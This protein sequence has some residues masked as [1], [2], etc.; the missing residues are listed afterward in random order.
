[1]QRFERICIFI[2]NYPRFIER[3]LNPTKPLQKT[4][5]EFMCTMLDKCAQ[6]NIYWFA[7]IDGDD[8]AGMAGKNLFKLFV[9]DHKGVHFGGRIRSTALNGFN[10]EN[11]NR[12][13]ADDQRVPG[14]G[15]LPSDDDTDVLEV[16]VPLAQRAKA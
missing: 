8:L 12:R 2:E 13:T 7:T 3:S 4:Y 11:Q 10:F 6:H 5:D 15:M 9:R 16:V 14:R 1:M